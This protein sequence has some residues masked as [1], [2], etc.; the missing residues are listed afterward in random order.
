[1]STLFVVCMKG[2]TLPESFQVIKDDHFKTAWRKEEKKIRL[3][4]G[5]E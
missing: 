1:M 5:P 4:A 2:S 3:K